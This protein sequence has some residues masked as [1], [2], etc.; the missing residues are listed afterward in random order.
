MP[1][2]G[3]ARQ[4]LGWAINYGLRS[5]AAASVSA[6]LHRYAVIF[7]YLGSTGLTTTGPVSGIRYRFDAPGARVRV[8]PRDR[9]GLSQIPRLRQV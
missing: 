5:A 2:C 9:K 4:A 6:P 3:K 8:D 7:E 1:C